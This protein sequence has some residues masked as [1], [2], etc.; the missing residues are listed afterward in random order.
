[1]H[2]LLSDPPWKKIENWLASLQFVAGVYMSG[3]IIHILPHEYS[4]R[5]KAA[6][7]MRIDPL[8][9]GW[10]QSMWRESKH[11]KIGK[12]PSSI[13]Q[14][15]QWKS[16]FSPCIPATQHC[17]SMER[18]SPFSLTSKWDSACNTTELQCH[19]EACAPNP[20]VPFAYSCFLLKWSPCC[21]SENW[22]EHCKPAIMVKIKIL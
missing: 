3:K 22:Q 21:T 12:S 1:M 11:L 9:R 20:K 18:S 4:L 13:I 14:L 16:S 7:A 19:L 2:I 10:W 6:S 5:S 17:T 8:R 15:P